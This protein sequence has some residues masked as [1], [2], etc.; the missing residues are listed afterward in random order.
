[1]SQHHKL[2]Q[3]AITNNHV[4]YQS[5]QPHR[6]DLAVGNICFQNHRHRHRIP[7]GFI[8]AHGPF[9]SVT[10][11]VSA[12]GRKQH[13]SRFSSHRQAI[14]NYPRSTM[15]ITGM[16]QAGDQLAGIVAAR[17]RHPSIMEVHA[18]SVPRTH[19]NELSLPVM[20]LVSWSSS[21]GACPDT[22]TSRIHHLWQDD[23]LLVMEY[24]RR[25]RYGLTRPP[26][27]TSRPRKIDK[28]AGLVR[29]PLRPVPIR[30]PPWS[31]S[32]R[33]QPAVGRRANV[34]E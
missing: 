33:P 10:I 18:P 28:I 29:P 24:R 8:V 19:P 34:D 13:H 32:R 12:R 31:P 3:T 20:A 22:R 23:G 16:T 7:R 25:L 5:C 9:T 30:R 26:P 1:M 15:R 4:A 14:S 2:D 6:N 21:S 27:I 17:A 11:K